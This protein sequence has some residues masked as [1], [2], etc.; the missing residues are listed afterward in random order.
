MNYQKKQIERI[1]LAAHKISE[2]Y[3]DLTY[4]FLE[5]KDNK[6]QVNNFDL[7]KIIREQLKYFEALAEKKSIE[8]TYNL[9]K[10]N[11]KIDENDFIRLFNNIISNAI[12]YN[13][14]KKEK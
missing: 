11:Y 3:K 2:I 6:S 7:D 4:V 9:E 13:K 10:F 14:K 8:I 5:D 12:K 1:K